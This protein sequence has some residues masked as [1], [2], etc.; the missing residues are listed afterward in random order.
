M[1]FFSI[2]MATVFV[3]LFSATAVNAESSSPVLSHME[4]KQCQDGRVIP[5]TQACDDLLVVTG[6]EE[7]S[8]TTPLE[9]GQMINITTDPYKKGSTASII[10][11]EQKKGKKV[12]LDSYFVTE[13]A[14]FTYECYILPTVGRDPTTVCDL[15]SQPVYKGES[16]LRLAQIIGNS[17][18]KISATVNLGPQVVFK[19][20]RGYGKG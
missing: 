6:E 20:T 15:M 11:F 7:L 14:V 17:V 2:S 18:S 19:K 16:P 8:F 5:F 9:S 10:F 1:K 12:F 3:G 4:A 13:E